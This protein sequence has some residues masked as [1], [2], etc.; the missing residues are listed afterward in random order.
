MIRWIGAGFVVL[1]LF[2]LPLNA[3]AGMAVSPLQQWVEVKPG[4][5]TTFTVIVTNVD[6][7]FGTLPCRVSVE[8]VDFTVSPEG[9]LSF[10][11]DLKHSRSAAEWITF[12]ADE[13]SL[14][15]GERKELKGKVS[16]PFKADGDYW[17]VI[18]VSLDNSKSQEKGINVNFRTASGVFVRVKRRNYA[19]RAS[20]I[21]ANVALPE[22]DPNEVLAG[23][24]N[25]VE[26]SQDPQA[27]QALKINAELKNDGLAAF[28]AKGKA[29]FYDE[30]W[31]RAG[32]IPLYT[33]R[34]RIFPGHTRCFTG[35]MAQ[36]LRAGK[37]KLRVVFETD[38][39]YGRKTTKDM[40]FSVSDEQ[41]RQWAENFTDDDIQMLEIE[42]QE[43][44]QTLT[45][46][47][48]TAAR[49]LVA[50]RGLSTVAIRCRLEADGL[51]ESWLQLKSA[52]FTLG[53][54][55]RRN[56]VCSVRI[57]QDAQPGEYNG[58]IHVEVERSGLTVQG[59]D[60]VELHKIPIRIALSK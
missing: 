34:R 25:D 9:G 28:L 60:N 27:K 40:E 52:E 50:N 10:G 30:N 20:I 38:S 11:E 58:T 15:P 44:K 42:P 2:I 12:D 17:A 57:P 49:F 45:P 31:R 18:M 14:E 56:V 47:R 35:V 5:E 13:F 54:N 37:Y 36:P 33:N 53:P 7:G 51:L 22:F 59:Q 26:I 55:M 41:A 23:E 3:I 43:F 24:P 32:S 8:V 19:E 21:D 29:F 39:N 16:A 46:G 48:F 6:R 1:F 4:K